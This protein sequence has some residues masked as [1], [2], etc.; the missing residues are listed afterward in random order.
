MISIRKTL[1]QLNQFGT[2]HPP[3][4]SLVVITHSP[5]HQSFH[6][7]IHAPTNPCISLAHQAPYP[8]ARRSSPKTINQR[9]T[10][11][12]L[13]LAVKGPD[14]QKHPR[15]AQ[16]FVWQL[17]ANVLRLRIV[18]V[19]QP[20]MWCQGI[21]NIMPRMCRIANML[22]YTTDRIWA[23]WQMQIIWRY[24]CCYFLHVERLLNCVPFE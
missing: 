3:N 22:H 19:F 18:V 24:S 5:T 23:T 17:M 13:H 21:R 7:P 20:A 8:S 6:P 9:I 11:W 12:C 16:R 4:H 15:M 1:H 10:C 14:I 2:Q